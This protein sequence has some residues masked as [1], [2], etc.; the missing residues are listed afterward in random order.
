MLTVASARIKV[1]SVTW[2]LRLLSSTSVTEVIYGESA[3]R[4]EYERSLGDPVFKQAY[5]LEP[6]A[7]SRV[8][9]GCTSCSIVWQ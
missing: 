6:I 7:S 5:W 3:A 2:T 8:S 1:L 9:V 4:A